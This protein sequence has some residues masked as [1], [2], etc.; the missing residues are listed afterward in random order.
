MYTLSQAVLEDSLCFQSFSGTHL[1]W[2]LLH[3]DGRTCGCLPLVVWSAVAPSR[4]WSPT[5]CLSSYL[6]Y[7]RTH[8]N[9]LSS[10]TFI[11]SSNNYLLSSTYELLTS[12]SLPST[13]VLM[14]VSGLE[15]HC[16][17]G[18]PALPLLGL[19]TSGKLP[20]CALVSSPVN[21]NDNSIYFRGRLGV[22]DVKSVEQC[23]V[24][25]QH[26]III[27]YYYLFLIYLF[28]SFLSSSPSI[29]KC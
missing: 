7:P 25:K 1:P 24:Y 29:I 14:F 5:R 23:L 12:S 27:S 22:E 17:G 19:L 11:Y 8:C 9:T 21:R 28:A 3:V 13:Y 15:P 20:L 10:V 26:S 16:Q 6:S 4:L 18:V 2:N